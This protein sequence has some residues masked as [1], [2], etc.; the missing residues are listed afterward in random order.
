L[1]AVAEFC[2]DGAQNAFGFG[3]D[4]RADSIAGEQN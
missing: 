3:D 2:G 1:K 4:F